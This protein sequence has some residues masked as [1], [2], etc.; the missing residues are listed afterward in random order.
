MM[1]SMCRKDG[2]F[3][4]EPL[5]GRRLGV[6]GRA[7]CRN[8]PSFRLSGVVW[9]CTRA[10][11]RAPTLSTVTL[12]T[13]CSPGLNPESIKK[14]TPKY[15]KYYAVNVPFPEITSSFFAF[16]FAPKGEPG[17]ENWRVK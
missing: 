2:A 16:D 11:R 10:L 5:L 8:Q 12:C 7:S 9:R 6:W 15:S 3:R 1:M 4:E 14:G 17:E 13:V